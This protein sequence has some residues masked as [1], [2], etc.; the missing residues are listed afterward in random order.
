MSKDSQTLEEADQLM[1]HSGIAISDNIEVQV[2][3]LPENPISLHIDSNEEENVE[4]GLG[5]KETTES[6]IIFKDGEPVKICVYMKRKPEV[7]DSDIAS[8]SESAEII[9]DNINAETDVT[10]YAAET[11]I[12]TTL[13]ALSDLKS[14][15]GSSNTHIDLQ[16]AGDSSDNTVQINVAQ[17]DQSELVLWSSA[18]N[19]TNKVHDTLSSQN[20]LIALVPVSGNEEPSNAIDISSVSFNNSVHEQALKC[21]TKRERDRVKKQNL[22][23][24]PAYR[25]KEREAAKARMKLRR[26]DPEYRNIERQKDRERRRISRHSNHKQREKERERDKDY[27]RRQR[28]EEWPFFLKQSSNETID[29]HL[30]KCDKTS[31]AS[32]EAFLSLLPQ[33]KDVTDT[34]EEPFIDLVQTES[35]TILPS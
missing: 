17:G 24:D 27:R 7:K 11:E 16:K 14:G 29:E 25:S 1:L 5:G 30:A 33:E 12:T 19:Y 15:V 34:I 2:E 23:K 18:T 28:S 6:Q 35:E 20:S 9:I 26:K 21:L 10:N 13:Q 8:S 3:L 32:N 31:P 22:R 4:N